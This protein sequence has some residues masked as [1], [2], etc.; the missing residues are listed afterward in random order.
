MMRENNTAE[1]V[2]LSLVRSIINNEKPSAL[3]DGITADEIF[4]IGSRQDM[5]PITFC[6]LNTITFKEMPCPSSICVDISYY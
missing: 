4:A 3:P 5:V 6:V 2:F 1:G